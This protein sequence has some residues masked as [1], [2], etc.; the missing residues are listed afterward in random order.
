MDDKDFQEY[1][2]GDVNQEIRQQLYKCFKKYG[3]GG[4]EDKIKEL[5]Q[6][7]PKIKELFLTEYW[8]IVRGKNA[9]P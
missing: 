5:Y 8:K 1:L 4:T 3:I 2:R 9:R 7:S 6:L